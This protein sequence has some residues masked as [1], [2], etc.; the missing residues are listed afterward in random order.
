VLVVD[1]D[2]TIRRIAFDV[3]SD[4]GFEVAL[5]DSGTAALES[6]ER[7][8]P[9]VILLDLTMPGMNGRAFH[10][11]LPPRFL[12]IPILLLS[13]SNDV[14]DAGLEL[15][16]AGVIAKPFDLDDLIGAVQRVTE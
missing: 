2:D 8:R 16:T 10:A 12:D 11:N 3:L 4:E 1:D 7:E 6:L 5:A 14:R 13:G 9:D 15:G